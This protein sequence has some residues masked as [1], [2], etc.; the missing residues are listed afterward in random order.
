MNGNK[1]FAPEYQGA[2]R[3]MSVNTAYEDVLEQAR[4]RS[5][6]AAAQGTA[7]ELAQA[8]LAVAEA[9]RRLGH[10]EEA[11]GSWKAAYR[12]ARTASDDGVRGWA[13]WSGGTLARQRGELNLALRLLA[14]GRDLSWQAGDITAY[15]YAFA[16]V[17]ETLRIQGDFEQA[18]G[19]HEH[20]LTEA[21]KREE[22]RHIVWALEGLAQIERNTGDLGSAAARFAEAAQVAEDSGDDRG[23]A[24]AL[25][26][27]A[28]V[29]SL[30]GEADQALELLSAAERTC[31]RMDLS[32]ALA[33][34]RK[35]RGNV[36]FRA[37]RHQEAARTYRDAHDKFRALR[38]P[39]GMA[40]ARLGLLK[41][42]DALGR[43]AE[44]TMADL[45]ALRDEVNGNELWQTRT[46]VENAIAERTA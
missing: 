6:W 1:A 37:G 23:H 24:W 20:V 31:R 10:L 18:R 3:D 11:D 12:A 34:N 39:R 16:G 27:Q 25:R 19:L 14:W 9:C 46:M 2:L 26:G 33:Y 8:E 40:L 35:M 15:G 4:D 7:L 30:R 43:P 45:V 44:A 21:R 41:S 17:A 5:R 36:Q 38:E 29:L 13:L 28:D 32:S 42:L 22:S